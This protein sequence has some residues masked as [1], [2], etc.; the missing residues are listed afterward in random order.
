MRS[1]PM[2]A[3]AFVAKQ[4]D[5]SRI[6]R[7]SL[8]HAVA[9]GS[10]GLLAC[11]DPSGPSPL[12][13]GTYGLS[14]CRF[15][16]GSP[17]QNLPCVLALNTSGDSLRVFDGILWLTPDT[18]WS[19]LIRT[20]QRLQGTWTD[21]QYML[22]GGHFQRVPADPTLFSLDILGQTSGANYLRVQGDRATLL[23]RWVF[24]QVDSAPPN[25]GLK[26]TAPTG[27]MECLRCH[28]GAAA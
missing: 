19:A 9:L 16:A 10:I 23:D 7:V 1:W 6:I 17:I 26:L 27:I 28:R 5:R 20:S 25:Y 24:D 18:A 3:F 21:D 22:L 4:S 8:R 14:G 15:E 2:Q 12:P 11:G 13:V